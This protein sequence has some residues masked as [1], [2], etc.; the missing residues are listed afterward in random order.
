MAKRSIPALVTELERQ[1]QQVAV[2]EARLAALRTAPSVFSLEVRRLERETLRRLNEL[3][4]VF[5]RN[6]QSARKVMERV[7]DGKLTFSPVES[8]D[9][10]RYRIEGP[11]T[12]GEMLDLPGD[13][14]APYCLRPQGDANGKALASPSTLSF[15]IRLVA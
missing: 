2:L 8:N 1:Q 11:V 7:L 14:A 15:E 3:R 5:V 13:L 9:G 12:L 10:K 4:D 6:P